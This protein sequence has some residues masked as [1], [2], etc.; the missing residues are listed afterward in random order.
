MTAPAPDTILDAL[1]AARASVRDAVAGIDGLTD[2]SA[3]VAGAIATDGDYHYSFVSAPGDAVLAALDPAPAALLATRLRDLA[4]RLSPQPE[5]ALNLSD[6]A[7][8]VTERARAAG[9]PYGASSS[10]DVDPAVVFADLGVDNREASAL[11]DA[12]AEQLLTQLADL[13][14]E[15]E[16]A[17]EFAQAALGAFWKHAVAVAAYAARKAYR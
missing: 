8:A 17:I 14:E 4:D 2:V 15:D 13:D 5:P 7:L 12:L 9:F 11:G 1:D 6:A 16:Q 3:T 10:D